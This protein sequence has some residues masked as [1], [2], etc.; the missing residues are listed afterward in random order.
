[1][2]SLALM[3]PQ[4]PAVT[5]LLAWAQRRRNYADHVNRIV[6]SGTD[7]PLPHPQQASCDHRA[8]D[9]AGAPASRTGWVSSDS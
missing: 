6:G 1:M 5:D 4:E 7:S 2:P 9:H 3:Q 8:S